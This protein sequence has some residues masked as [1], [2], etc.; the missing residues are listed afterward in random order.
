MGT[1]I[2]MDCQQMTDPA[3]LLDWSLLRTMQ[4]PA[5]VQ[6]FNDLSF[7]NCKKP[8]LVWSVTDEGKLV[9]VAGICDIDFKNCHCQLLF[10]CP[11]K[12]EILNGLIAQVARHVFEKLGLDKI[13]CL[14]PTDNQACQVLEIFGFKTEAVLRR[15]CFDGKSRVDVK[16][17]GLFRG[18]SG[19]HAD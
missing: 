7:P 1:K 16:W 10:A 2:S 3:L 13:H 12:P 5:V 4:A 11:Q 6:N 14:V 9:G 17:Y 15:H 8:D 18:E 19:K